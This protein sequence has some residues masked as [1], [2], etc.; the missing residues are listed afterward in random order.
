MKTPKCWFM[1]LYQVGL[2][3][4]TAYSLTCPKKI[5]SNYK[6]MRILESID[7]FKKQLKTLFFKDVDGV[8]HLRTE[9]WVEAQLYSEGTLRCM[10]Q[11]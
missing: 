5:F 6:K 4:V 3:I 9:K 11:T 1:L 8:K 10:I 2:T 7:T